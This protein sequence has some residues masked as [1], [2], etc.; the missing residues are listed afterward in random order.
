MYINNADCNFLAHYGVLGM[1]WGIRRYQ[2]PDGTRTALGKKHEKSLKN[3]PTRDEIL[4]S[5]DPKLIYKHKE[6]LTD[7]ELRDRV[8]RIQTEQQLEQLIKNSTKESQGKKFAKRV[9][10][11][12]GTMAVTAMAGTIFKGGQTAIPKVLAKIGA[13][14]VS[15][16]L[17]QEAIDAW[18]SLEK[19][20][21]ISGF[22]K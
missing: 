5:T 11:S 1:K 9:V 17:V 2:N 19:L 15:T 4:K 16:A 6:K 18:D 3:S 13:V 21:E 8:N 7:K 10:A 12:V 20:E 22:N 14:A